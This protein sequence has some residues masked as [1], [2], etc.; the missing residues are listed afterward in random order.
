[1]VDIPLG[2]R[3]VVLARNHA[4]LS[5]LTRLELLLLT[6]QPGP[7]PFIHF[8]LLALRVM[9]IFIWTENRDSLVL[10]VYVN[11]ILKSVR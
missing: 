7:Q 4:G 8:A 2:G 11:N 6:T 5:I 9:D 10:W 3:H 1:M